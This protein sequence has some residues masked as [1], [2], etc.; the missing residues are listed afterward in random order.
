[1]CDAKAHGVTSK[2]RFASDPFVFS[3]KTVRNHWT[4]SL[5]GGF[6]KSG[7]RLFRVSP[8]DYAAIAWDEIDEAFESELIRREVWIDVGVIVFE[9]RNDQM[10]GMIVEKLWAAIPEGGFVFVAFENH[11][12]SLPE[13]IAL[14]EVF[15]DAAHEK[16]WL[17]SGGVK[18]P[19]KHRSSGG[20]S[21]RAADDNGMLSGKENFLQDF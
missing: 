3:G 8:D 21:V 6:A 2:F 1:M 17:L 19:G 7:T 9:G 4:E 18:N 5:C 14:A 15:G 11:F 12:A 10:I 16:S 13:A 20:F